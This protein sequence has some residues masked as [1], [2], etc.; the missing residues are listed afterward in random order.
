MAIINKEK[1]DEMA[2]KISAEA[3]RIRAGDIRTYLQHRKIGM[4]LW[5][6]L[7]YM[8]GSAVIGAVIYAVLL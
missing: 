6:L 5:E 3:D 8:A 2:D 1:L 7:A 4:K